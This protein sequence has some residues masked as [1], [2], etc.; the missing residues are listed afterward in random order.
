MT[1]YC[2][3]V[4][5]EGTRSERWKLGGVPHQP[6]SASERGRVLVRQF[7]EAIQSGDVEQLVGTLASDVVLMSDGGGKVQA[8]SR[9]LAGF[10]RVGRFLSAVFEDGSG[11]HASR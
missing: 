11:E 7:L 8:A 1:K 3:G 2:N 6:P 10:S 4:V 9:P 5:R